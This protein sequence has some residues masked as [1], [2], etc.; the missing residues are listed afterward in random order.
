MRIDFYSIVMSIAVSGILLLL[1]CFVRR[2]VYAMQLFGIKTISA[3]Y[4]LCLI[5]FLV[6][7]DLTFSESIALP[8]FFHDFYKELCLNTYSLGKLEF[9]LINVFVSVWFVIAG[10]RIL[11]FVIIYFSGKNKLLQTGSSLN[12]NYQP[13]INEIERD[14]NVFYKVRIFRTDQVSGPMGVG[15][16][17]KVILLPDAEY[18][19]EELYYILLHEYMHFHNKDLLIKLLVHI[20]SCLFWWNPLSYLLEKDLAQILEIKCDHSVADLVGESRTADYLQAIIA[21]LKKRTQQPCRESEVNPVTMSLLGNQTVELTERFSVMVDAQRMKKKGKR[22]QIFVMTIVLCFFASSYLIIFR[23]EFEPPVSDIITDEN[24]YEVT[25]EEYYIT[26][27][28]DGTYTLRDNNGY[29]QE[30]SAEHAKIMLKQNF[31]LLEE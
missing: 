31:R 5:R 16:L 4:L 1:L 19:E 13:I 14:T 12:I 9:R 27:E 6:P 10:I 29:A 25:A 28:E 3:L 11:H 20:Y 22:I 2:K 26:L 17:D 24:T 18:S 30:I 7:V 15:I 23:C 8:V 21:V